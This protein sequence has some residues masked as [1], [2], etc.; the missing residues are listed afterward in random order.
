MLSH[1]VPPIFG[2][3]LCQGL[4][5]TLGKSIPF[6]TGRLWVQF[7]PGPPKLALTHGYRPL[8]AINTNLPHFAPPLHFPQRSLNPIALTP[9]IAASRSPEQDA[10]DWIIRCLVCGARNIIIPILKFVGWRYPPSTSPAPTLW[11]F[12]ILW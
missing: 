8:Q 1:R 5:L 12:L 2:R 4:K 11:G 6:A 7:P 9:H 10:G 3:C